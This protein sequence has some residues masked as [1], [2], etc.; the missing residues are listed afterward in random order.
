MKYFQDN[1]KQST[2]KQLWKS[3]ERLIFHRDQPVHDDDHM[4]SENKARRAS[5]KKQELLTPHKH[6]GHPRVYY[7]WYFLLRIKQDEM[8]LKN[9]YSLFCNIML[10]FF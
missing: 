7:H 3:F 9:V 5:Y 6:L 2:I 4:I 1:V 8:T 10:V